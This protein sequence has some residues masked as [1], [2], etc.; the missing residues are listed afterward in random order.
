MLTM[1]RTGVV[2]GLC[3]AAFAVAATSAASAVEVTVDG[4][5]YEVSTFFGSYTANSGSFDT[6]SMPWWNDRA[7]AKSVRDAYLDATSPSGTYFAYSFSGG[8]VSALQASSKSD[9]TSN[10][11]SADFATY[12]TATEVPAEIPEIDGPVLAQLVA[13][14][15]AGWLIVAARRE[16]EGGDA[17]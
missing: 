5:T 4:V 2:T 8:Q 16:E 11:A 17:A 3:A 9:T 6:A 14:L 7:L 15:G 10:L 12:A 1:R 13:V